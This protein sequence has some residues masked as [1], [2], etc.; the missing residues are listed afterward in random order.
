[1]KENF[2][3]SQEN[4]FSLKQNDRFENFFETATVPT[5]RDTG[6]CQLAKSHHVIAWE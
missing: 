6:L 5:W 2:S 1:M 3:A 4:T